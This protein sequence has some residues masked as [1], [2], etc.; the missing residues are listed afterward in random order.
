MKTETI[1]A[2]CSKDQS[3]FCLGSIEHE[4]RQFEAGGGCITPER[5]LAYP[6]DKGE[7]TLWDGQ[8]I[9]TYQWK[10]SKNA[11]FF[12]YHSWIGSR[13]YYGQATV[14]GRKYAIQGF[15]AGMLARGKA[16]KKQ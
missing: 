1:T 7:L 15:G 6:N 2:T 12:G 8:V 11:I 9:G 14:N 10:S 4:G 3:T 16:Y 13:Y 5:L